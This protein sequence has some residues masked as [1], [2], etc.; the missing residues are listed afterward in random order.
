MMFVGMVFGIDHGVGD[1]WPASEYRRVGLDG[2]QLGLDL[3]S[4]GLGDAQQAFLCKGQ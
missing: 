4:L 2:V 3:F 1:R